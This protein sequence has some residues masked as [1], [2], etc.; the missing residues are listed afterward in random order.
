MLW[1]IGDSLEVIVTSI[2]EVRRAETEEYCHL[3]KKVI[4]LFFTQIPQMDSLVV[5]PFVRTFQ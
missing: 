1:D 5:N 3:K 4:R 2:T